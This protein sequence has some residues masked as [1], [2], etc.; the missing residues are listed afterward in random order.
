MAYSGQDRP[1]LPSVS[2]EA[3]EIVVTDEMIE[4]GV[5]ALGLSGYDLEEATPHEAVRLVFLA[6][7]EALD[8]GR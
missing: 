2:Q 8:Q 7:L 5:M 6:M 1:A 3:G 4:A